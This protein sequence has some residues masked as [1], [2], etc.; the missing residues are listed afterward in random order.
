V[1]LLHDCPWCWAPGCPKRWAQK[2]ERRGSN[3]SVTTHGT[4]CCHPGALPMGGMGVDRRP[5]CRARPRPDWPRPKMLDI[6]VPGLYDAASPI[7]ASHQ[8]GL[9]RHKARCVTHVSSCPPLKTVRTT[10]MVYG[11]APAVV[12]RASRSVPSHFASSTGLHPWTACAFAGY[13]W[14]GLAAG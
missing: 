14:S 8:A 1:P 12:L 7:G 2:A 6:R 5:R 10:F 13:L 9:G 3:A 4:Q 11:L